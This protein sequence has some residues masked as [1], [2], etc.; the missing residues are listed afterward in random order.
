[1]VTGPAATW[2]WPA[3]SPTSGCARASA[4]TCTTQYWATGLVSGGNRGTHRSKDALDS[5]GVRVAGWH[6]GLHP[7]VDAAS[8]HPPAEGRVLGRGSGD[9]EGQEESPVDTAM[10]VL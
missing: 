8:T 9:R 3:T 6:C 1:M 7:A 2:S 10:M 5:G 4:Q